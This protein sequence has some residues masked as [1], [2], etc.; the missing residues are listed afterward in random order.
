MSATSWRKVFVAKKIEKLEPEVKEKVKKLYSILDKV[1]FCFILCI[2]CGAQLGLLLVMT[3]TLVCTLLS[4]NSVCQ[5]ILKFLFEEPEMFGQ[6]AF[7][8][9]IA[10]PLVLWL[11]LYKWFC[12][13][14]KDKLQRIMAEDTNFFSTLEM[15]KDLDPDMARNIKKFLPQKALN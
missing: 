11:T 3:L 7:A 6:I 15:V 4:K 9:V 1:E 5:T 14:Q 13:K 2:K 8:S 10:T 12:H